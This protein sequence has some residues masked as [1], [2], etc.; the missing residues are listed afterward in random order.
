MIATGVGVTRFQRMMLAKENDMTDAAPK[1]DEN[2]NDNPI[3]K[4]GT[5]RRDTSW[6]NKPVKDDYHPVPAKKQ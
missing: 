6:P 3:P 5:Y 1:E 4:P 2:T